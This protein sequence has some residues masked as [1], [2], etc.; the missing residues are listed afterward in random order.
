M[1]IHAGI[2]L[3][4]LITF[5][6]LNFAQKTEGSFKVS[7]SVADQLNG[8]PLVGTT[9]T[10]LSRN[11]EKTLAGGISDNKGVFSIEKI[12]EPVV[13]VRLSMVGYQTLVI[14]SADLDHSSRLGLIKLSQAAIV[15]PE[16]VI[17]SLKPMIEFHADRQV[18]NMDRLPGNSGSVTEALKNSGAVEVDPQS[19]K[20]TVR[21]QEVKLQMDG[22]QYDMPSDMLSQLPATMIDQVEVILAPGAKESAEG[23][24]YILNLVS[25]KNKVDNYNG[26]ISY[27]SS[28][29]NS[30]FGGLNLNY[31]VNKLNL[32]SQAY[33]GYYEFHGSGNTERINYISNSVHFQD[34]K[35]ESHNYGYSGYFKLGMD[36]DFDDQNSI[37]LYGSYNKYKNE[38][39]SLGSSNV[40]NT[41]NILQYEYSNHNDYNSSYNGLSFYGFYKRKFAGKGHELTFDAMYTGL[42]NPM[43]SRMNLDYSNRPG[44]PQLQT[45]DQGVDSKTVIV[46]TDYALPLN[47]NRFEAG[48]NFTYRN[49]KN[50]YGVL[51]YSYAGYLWRDSMGLSNVF[52]YKENIHALYVTY[53]HKIDKLDIKA[54]LRMEDLNTKGEQITTSEIFTQNFVSLFPNLN[55]SY[56]FSDLLQLG[57]TGFR[58]VRYP[59]VYFVNPFKQYSGPNAYFAGNPKLEPNFINSYAVN[60]SQYINAYYVYST[61]LFTNAS[62]IENDSTL[63]YSY[64]NL[65]NSKT[66]GIDL[67]LPYYN[68]P[69]MPFHLPDFINMINLQYS[70][71]YRDQ[72]GKYTSEDMSYIDRSYSLRANIGLN[73][74]FNISA[75]ISFYYKPE[76]DNRLYR[77]REMK[78][79]SLYLSKSFMDQKLRIN[80]SV[81]DLLNAQKY[82]NYTNGSNFSTKSSYTMKNSQSIMLGITYMFNDY[83]ERRDRNIDD[84]RDGRGNSGGGGGGF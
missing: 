23:G 76:T 80:L 52:K 43:D 61:G 4:L 63:I 57:F 6:S 9:V 82:D 21:G 60:L 36:Y 42:E 81:N 12:S 33:G 84:G 19:N 54:G 25:K 24:T 73:L 34:S 35:N 39:N 8:K 44:R 20:I 69:M 10:I 62:A 55:I 56:K 40:R 75:N 72:R 70:F 46:K 66:Y 59:M 77:S 2:I 31:K 49:R 27:S 18:L 68:T 5:T 74:W 30:N 47:Q 67:T 65:N 78:D 28:T 1:K 14:D 11:A 26:S 41:Q 45:T 51:D 71:L 7:G 50:D 48:Y 83:K 22:H 16:I 32:F 29:N 37:T 53:S 79:L 17:K 64:I 13:R 3:F 15:M 38:S 58:R